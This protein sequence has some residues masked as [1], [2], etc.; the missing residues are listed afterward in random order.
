M[1]NDMETIAA[2][3]QE[4]AVPQGTLLFVDDE[5]FILSSLKRLFRPLGYRVFTAEGGA[6]GLEV[7]AAEKIDLVIS[8]MRMPEMDGAQFLEQ[9]RLKSPDT[10]RLLLTGFA[11]LDST[12]AAINKG[13][14]YRYIPKPWE[15]NDLV[16]AVRHA[17]ERKQLEREKT[18]LEVLTR[19]QNEELKALNA[20]LE[21]KV[22]ER[23]EELRRTLGLLEK[24][25][26][27]LKKSFLT[28]IRIFSNLME[29]RDGSITG[30]SRRVADL[31]RK[32]ALKLG[33]SEVEAQEIMVA[34]LLHDIG[35]IG[36]PDHLLH[37]PFNMLAGE[38]RVAV[39]KHPALGQAALMSLEQLHGAARLIRGHHERYDG[40]GYPD[41]LAGDVI[42]LGARILAVANDYDAVQLGR[43]QNKRLNAEDALQFIREGR[44]RRYDPKVSDALVDLLGGKVE[45]SATHERE[46][47]LYPAELKPGMA[48]TRD[49]VSRDGLLL[50]A[51]DYLLDPTL[52]EQLRNYER[53]EGQPLP[54][55]IRV[56]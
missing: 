22:R 27:S 18:R 56:H 32:L 38:E 39:M 29:L 50:L 23:T 36:L 7:V 24:A 12:I 1:D 34:G 53:M 31:G 43:L 10:I 40:Q 42:P 30:H 28:S 54:I 11:D 52:I 19:R 8:D 5:P 4:P 44:S 9:V 46:V 49:L 33:L 35:K 48:L 55:Y 15:D 2:D 16:L 17:L 41:G 13:Q 14:I 37:K 26:E 25:H 3:S 6:Q 51:R 21:E 45:A 47:V 20:G